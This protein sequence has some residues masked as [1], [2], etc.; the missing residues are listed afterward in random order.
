MVD[1]TYAYLLKGIIF[2]II[3]LAL[4]LWRKDIRKEMLIISVIFAFAGPLANLP[5][6]QDWWNPFFLTNIPLEDFLVGFM[7]GGIAAVIYEIAFAK[8]IKSKIKNKKKEL[9][10]NINFL[11]IISLLAILFFGSF[12]LLKLNSLLSTII[13]FVVP[14]AI[15]WIKRK[16]LILDS[17]ISGV[18]LLVVAM[19]VYTLLELLTPGWVQAFWLFENIPNIVILNVPLDDVIWYFL[20]GAFIGPLYEYWQEGKLINAKK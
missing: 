8:K 2:L 10:R 5:Y 7:I 17:L 16:D 14:L 13:A 1:Y 9:E 20:A 19:V 18:L 15:I 11:T 3:W 12:Y 4:F 6:L